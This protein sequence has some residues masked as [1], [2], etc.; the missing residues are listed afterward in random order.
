ML[1][2]NFHVRDY[3]RHHFEY[4]KFIYEIDVCD[5]DVVVWGPIGN[6]GYAFLVKDNSVDWEEYPEHA[7]LLPEEVMRHVEGL[8]S[9]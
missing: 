9:K 1:E 4:H 8:V 7:A 6:L 3:K 5:K 2:G